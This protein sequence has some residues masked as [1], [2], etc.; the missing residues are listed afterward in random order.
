M[1]SSLQS[2]GERD[3]DHE[4]GTQ[5]KPQLCSF[6]CLEEMQIWRS[7]EV[8]ANFTCHLFPLYPHGGAREQCMKSS[9][10]AGRKV[11]STCHFTSRGWFSCLSHRPT[12]PSLL[13]ATSLLLAHLLLWEKWEEVD[14]FTRSSLTVACKGPKQMA[15]IITQGNLYLH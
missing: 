6:G 9:P 4:C 3:K 1:F 10:V 12:Q 5:G 11:A 13:Q 15:A 2:H 14:V 7:S 8:H